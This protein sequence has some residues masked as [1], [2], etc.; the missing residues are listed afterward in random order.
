[1][2]ITRKLAIQKVWDAPDLVPEVADALEAIPD[3]LWDSSDTIAELVE[4]S[5]A[6][7]TEAGCD[8][9]DFEQVLGRHVGQEWE[10]AHR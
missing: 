10:E 5:R 8:V 3:D 4:R 7:I 1:M 9:A 6:A 2:L